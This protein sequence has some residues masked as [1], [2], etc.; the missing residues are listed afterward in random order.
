MARKSRKTLKIDNGNTIV[1]SVETVPETAE[2]T[3][4]KTPTVMYCRLSKADVATGKDSMTSQIDIIRQ[5]SK[6]RM[7]W[8]S[9]R[10]FWTTVIPA[11]ITDG[12][13]LRK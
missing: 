11:R 12:R 7:T 2:E 6:S 8:K 5:L 10:R 13:S 3:S 9:R 4:A 1:Q